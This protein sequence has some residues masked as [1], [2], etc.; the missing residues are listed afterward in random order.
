MTEVKY[1]SS[2]LLT[3][4]LAAGVTTAAEQD[5]TQ[6]NVA[7][8]ADAG[9]ATPESDSMQTPA[10]TE[11]AQPMAETQSAPEPMAAGSVPR[12]AFATDIQDHEPV[13][14]IGSLTNDNNKV[15]FFTELADLSGQK[16]IH[17]WEYNGEV[18]AEVPF[19]V[20]GDRWRGWS[21]KN[22][23]PGWT[24]DWK[25]DVVNGSGDVIAS[26]SLQYKAAPQQ[27]AMTDAEEAAAPVAETGA[28]MKTDES[29]P[30]EAQ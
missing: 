4:L 2:I 26:Q 10:T 5:A 14:Q 11:A 30:A 19:N 15:Y 25:V 7:E 29:A 28:D 21:S 22:L 8:A 6:S 16:V 13:D 1:L 9:M 27:A 18:I 12:S 20:K 17:R 3:L 23:E 24:G